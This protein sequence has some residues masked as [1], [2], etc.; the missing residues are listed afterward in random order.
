MATRDPRLW[1]GRGA[2]EHS[3]RAEALVSSEGGRIYH[4]NVEAEPAISPT[5]PSTLHSQPQR[6][7][8][9]IGSPL[10]CRFNLLKAKSEAVTRR[11]S[12]TA[13]MRGIR[14]LIFKELE[15][16]MIK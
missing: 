12:N 1:R 7:L 8:G 4:E 14:M 16:E 9:R 10:F 6:S 15:L 5:L 13:R 3:R 2:R 11:S